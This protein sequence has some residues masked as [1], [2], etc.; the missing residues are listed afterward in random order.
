[1]ELQIPGLCSNHQGKHRGQLGEAAEQRWGHR[2]KLS[3]DTARRFQCVQLLNT[4]A[5]A[6][7]GALT[8]GQYA[9][10]AVKGPKWQQAWLFSP[11]TQVSIRL[12]IRHD[13]FY[14]HETKEI[15]LLNAGNHRLFPVW[16]FIFSVRISSNRKSLEVD[17]PIDQ[18]SKQNIILAATFPLRCASFLTSIIELV[19]LFILKCKYMHLVVPGISLQTQQSQTDVRIKRR[20]TKEK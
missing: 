6:T 3:Y 15:R 2:V 20:V 8:E 14:L 5:F 13:T 7:P 12:H 19:S 1:M 16:L 4:P 17:F 9:V 10:G 18:V 11:K